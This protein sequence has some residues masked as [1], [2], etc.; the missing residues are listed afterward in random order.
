VVEALQSVMAALTD[1]PV[2]KRVALQKVL[3]H[4]ARIHAHTTSQV[5][6]RGCMGVYYV[7]FLKLRLRS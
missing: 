7:Q 4:Y 1:D 3:D 5:E 6:V 2:S